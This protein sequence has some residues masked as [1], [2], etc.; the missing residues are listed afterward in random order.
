LGDAGGISSKITKNFNMT[1]RVY[2]EAH[3]QDANESSTK[4]VIIGKNNNKIELPFDK[5]K[6][7]SNSRVQRVVRWKN[8]VKQLEKK[9]SNIQSL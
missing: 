1:D 6:I 2:L 3:I 5:S 8:K 7:F 4:F 9:I